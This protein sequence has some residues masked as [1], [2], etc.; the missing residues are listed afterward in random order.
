M[1]KKHLTAALQGAACG[2]AVIIFS[3]GVVTTLGALIKLIGKAAGC[4]P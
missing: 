1:N 3:I 4:A 2:A